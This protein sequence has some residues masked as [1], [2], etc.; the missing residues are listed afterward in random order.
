MLLLD[1]ESLV[2]MSLLQLSESWLLS[3]ELMLSLSELNKRL[4]FSNFPF[5]FSSWIKF[6]R[7][8]MLLFEIPVENP[9]LGSNFAFFV[10]SLLNDVAV[11]FDVT[12]FPLKA[13][14]GVEFWRLI[15]LVIFGL[16]LFS[17]DTKSRHDND[18]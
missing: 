7:S 17:F 10:W 13:S 6:S 16:E 4:L 8:L 3:E 12:G 11:L 15:F 18:P 1:E 14:F 5:L 9:S 2:E